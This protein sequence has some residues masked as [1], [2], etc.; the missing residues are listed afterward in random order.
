[1][2]VDLDKRTMAIA[3]AHNKMVSEVNHVIDELGIIQDPFEPV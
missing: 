3:E 2:V 1:M